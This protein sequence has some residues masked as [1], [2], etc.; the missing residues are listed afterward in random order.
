MRWIAFLLVTASTLAVV[1]KD[2]AQ[3]NAGSKD[4]KFRSLT[5][6][7]SSRPVIRG[8]PCSLVMAVANPTG[9][10]DPEFAGSAQLST[11]DSAASI[12]SSVEILGAVEV[13]NVLFG[14]VGI[15]TVTARVKAGPF[16]LEDS[17]SVVVLPNIAEFPCP[18]IVGDVNRDGEITA[19]DAELLNKIVI[20]DEE[21]VFPS[22]CSH[23]LTGD[24]T[25]DRRLGK[26][27]VA[28]LDALTPDDIVP[29][30]G[31]GCRIE[32]LAPI[33]GSYV[34]R[35][36][37][38]IDF[39]VH[40][41]ELIVVDEIGPVVMLCA[42]RPVGGDTF[43]SIPPG[44]DLLRAL[45]RN[46]LVLDDGTFSLS[47]SNL[48]PIGNVSIHILCRS[49]SGSISCAELNFTVTGI[50]IVRVTPL[51]RDY[52]PNAPGRPSVVLAATQIE[53]DADTPSIEWASASKPT[54]RQGSATSL[55]AVSDVQVEDADAALSITAF[56]TRAIG[57][58]AVIDEDSAAVPLQDAKKE[59]QPRFIGF[60]FKPFFPKPP[61][62][63]ELTAQFRIPED[64]EGKMWEMDEKA[65]DAHVTDI[66]PPP[67][68]DRKLITAFSR[69]SAPLKLFVV[70]R[71]N[72]D[73]EWRFTIKAK[74][75]FKS[76]RKDKKDVEIRY[77]TRWSIFAGG[78]QVGGQPQAVADLIDGLKKRL[79]DAQ[80]KI[81][82]L[83][84][85]EKDLR[86]K[87]PRTADEEEILKHLDALNSMKIDFARLLKCAAKFELGDQVVHGSTLGDVA[88][89][90]NGNPGNRMD[91][92]VQTGYTFDTIELSPSFFP[93][94]RNEILRTFIHEL[95]HCTLYMEVNETVDAGRPFAEVDRDRDG[96]E[97]SERDPSK[98]D[99]QHKNPDLH[100]QEAVTEEITQKLLE[101]IRF[102]ESGK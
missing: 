48:L 57:G 85:Q 53:P 71:A 6:G 82:E 83:R 7:I 80:K 29:V 10:V 41:G 36:D 96:L 97:D 86:A 94:G 100:D 75:K 91:G 23:I 32:I 47:L 81:D 12:P 77:E 95:V 1:H 63:L 89:L 73:G 18:I 9:K 37:V 14:T 30:P 54:P 39:R 33:E 22:E 28:L 78:P 50:D 3:D 49:K 92:D 11:S 5:L 84:A 17:L 101:A 62:T 4:P 55:S 74:G 72:S 66:A 34:R 51:E 43:G 58:A 70:F 67:G 13:R 46:L 21:V 40:D 16:Q 26:D 64:S 19:A 99:P 90:A 31:D 35:P 2:W 52:G 25:G 27:D 102:I 87:S 98:G 45:A 69:E 59:E 76:L 24:L 20:G 61:E 88:A 8:V 38:R 93:R 44:T 65:F 56:L 42:N 68:V 15:H 79:S 60:H